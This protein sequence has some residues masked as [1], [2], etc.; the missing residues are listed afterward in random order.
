MLSRPQGHSATGRI[1]SM[2]KSN[3]T[4]GN[5]TRDLPACRAVLQPTAPPRAPL[6][7]CDS[8]QVK[9]DIYLQPTALEFSILQE[10]IIFYYFRIFFCTNKGL[11]PVCVDTVH[12]FL[13]RCDP[14]RF[15]TSS[16]LRFLD[17]TL[18][19]TTFSGTSLDEWS[20]RRRN[21]Y[22]ITYNTHNRQTS[23]PPVEFEPTISVGE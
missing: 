20:A 21:L 13:W 19:R 16:F 2:K 9:G 23:M 10:K 12:F 11:C 7:K 17:H 3:D 14:T 4:T 15:M 22:L 6:C 5:R 18:R 8:W 1:M